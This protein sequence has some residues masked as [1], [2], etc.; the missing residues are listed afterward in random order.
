MTLF[1]TTLAFLIPIAI[2]SGMFGH[3]DVVPKVA[4][5]LCAS[6]ILDAP[7]G[8]TVPIVLSVGTVSSNTATIAI[9]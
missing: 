2:A 5:I 6:A 8:P 7:I 1:L 4:L 9:Q 3:Y